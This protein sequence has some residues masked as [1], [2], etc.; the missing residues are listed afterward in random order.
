[1]KKRVEAH[2]ENLYEV[3]LNIEGFDVMSDYTELADN[4]HGPSPTGFILTA[5]AACV[6]MTARSYLNKYRISIDSLDIVADGQFE[7]DDQ[8][9]YLISHIS[10]RI[11]PSETPIDKQ[12]FIE[13][14]HRYCRVSNILS[15]NRNQIYITIESTHQ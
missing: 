10:I 9:Y 6:T 4:P 7:Q 15:S 14:I 8:G 13:Y 12:A 11:S 2:N 3:H 1:M 5:L